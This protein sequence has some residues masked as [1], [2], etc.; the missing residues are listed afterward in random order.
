MRKHRGKKSKRHYKGGMSKLNP[1]DY[2]GKGVGTS[3]VGVQ[4]EA[5]TKSS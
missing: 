2:D 1:A 3:G 5:T 4:M